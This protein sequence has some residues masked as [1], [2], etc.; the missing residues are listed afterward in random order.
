MRRLLILSH[1]YLGIP[2][3]VAFVVWFISGIVMIYTRGFPTV[4]DDD[5]LA[6]MQ[7]IDIAVLQL[8][9][10]AAWSQ[11]GMRGEPG[12]VR[13]GSLL[14]RPAWTYDLSFGRELR[15][16]ADNGEVLNDLSSEQGAAVDLEGYGGGAAE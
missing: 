6:A 10:E 1:R 15:M 3:S 9:A 5:R 11:A 7:P 2:L 8:S 4:T 14:G 12:G 13:L 16:F